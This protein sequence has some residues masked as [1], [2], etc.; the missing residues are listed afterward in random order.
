VNATCG[1]YCVGGGYAAN[2]SA[3]LEIRCP[4]NK[5]CCFCGQNGTDL[6]LGNGVISGSSSSSRVF[7]AY[8]QLSMSGQFE[9][10]GMGRRIGSICW[11]NQPGCAPQNLDLT[12]VVLVNTLP[13]GLD[14]NPGNMTN[15]NGGT[16][17]YFQ[18][19]Y[20]DND[21]ATQTTPLPFDSSFTQFTA[22]PGCTKSIAFNISAINLFLGVYNY[23]HPCASSIG[24]CTG[25]Q[26]FYSCRLVVLDNLRVGD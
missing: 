14:V 23:S 9:L 8:L 13:D 4:S 22:G 15:I 3:Q 19:T 25:I 11:G 1:G 16:Y 2:F 17:G 12:N 20:I 5:T 7:A 21:G 18:Y 24:Y 6:Q 26:D 10:H